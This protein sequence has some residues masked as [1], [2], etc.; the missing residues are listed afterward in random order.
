MRSTQKRRWARMVP[1]VCMTG[2]V[3]GLALV[4]PWP[5]LPAAPAE[6]I[7]AGVAPTDHAPFPASTDEAWLVPAAKTPATR[8]LR[9]LATGLQ[10]FTR[11]DYAEALLAVSD[12]RHTT[13]PLADYAA[14]Y[15]A[16]SYLR[17]ARPAEARTLLDRLRARPL[18]GYLAEAV[19]LA[20]AEAAEST[21]D[22]Q[23]ALAI[24]RGL[25]VGRLAA[26]DA[27]LDKLA[28][29]AV[30]TGDAA[31]AREAFLRLYAEFPQSPLAAG[32]AAEI[33]AMRTTG[34][35]DDARQLFELDLERAELLFGGRR[36]AEALEAFRTLQPLA[37]GDERERVDLRM[38]ESLYYLGRYRQALDALVG[39]QE[40]ASR[41]AE[42]RFF[43]AQALRG[44]GDH[45]LYE[46]RAHA[47]VEEFAGTS[48]AED[49]LNNLGTHYILRDEDD[50]ANEI[51]RLVIERFPEGRHAQ[52][53]SWKYGW[54]RYRARDFAAAATIF[55]QA[56]VR[57]PRSDYR[58]AWLYWAGK[59]RDHLRERD[60]A[61]ALLQLVTVDYLNSYYGRLASRILAARGLQPG[62]WNAGHEAMTSRSM[63]V[64]WRPA[65]PGTVVLAASLGQV[66]AAP[67]G[68]LPP[69]ADTV[70]H[71]LQIG[72]LDAAVDELRYAERT[73]G[74]SPVITATL[75]W[76]ANQQGDYR[77][78]IILM[79]RA[80][81][82]YIAVGGEEMPRPLLEIIFPL[83]YW[84]LIRRHSGRHDLDPYLIAALMAQES[85]FLPAVRSSANAYGLMQ[86]V[87]A[88]GR[89]VAR[90]EGIR[91]F[92]TSMLTDPEINVRLGTRYFAGLVNRFGGT[93][94]ALA[95]YNA[96]ESR[97]VRWKA[98]RPGLDQDEFI[99]DIPFP[100]TQHYVKRI[101]GSSED[102][103]R[104]YGAAAARG[105]R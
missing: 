99:D 101:L 72:A 16:L 58:P 59:A 15:T 98:E 85:S 51:F 63:P 40:R 88:T 10:A 77:R 9:D 70:R 42:A 55:E 47:L 41:L 28:R 3:V 90:Q 78:G 31:G 73:W 83:E 35:G 52:R 93:H 8:E 69:N 75:A 44:L 6:Q 32:A 11:G 36:Y 38:G 60:A 103:R 21:G 13:G 45:A 102:Y 14:Y 1:S 105:S 89:R 5:L 54:S 18:V 95:S 100:E 46:K 64:R 66:P 92:R 12:G 62:V 53:A 76:I 94:F 65:G 7:A 33:E 61:N 22:V 17:L 50:K 68:A 23:T 27:A 30:R 104:L 67:A 96:G 37:A 20:A 56:S 29:A 71:L 74:T 4:G 81:P 48:W 24:Y 57:A 34:G 25:D 79:K 80:Y 87:P 82:Q 97:V 84:D 43:Y 19:P 2:V 91:R 39:Y 49:A 26:P 86:V